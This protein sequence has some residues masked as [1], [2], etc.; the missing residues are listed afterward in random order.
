MTSFASLGSALQDAARRWKDRPA[1]ITPDCTWTYGEL[2]RQA[3]AYRAALGVSGMA[4]RE[5]VGVVCQNIMQ[6]AAA[7]VAT[8]LEGRVVLGVDSAIPAIR[9]RAIMEDAGVSRILSDPGTAA[10]CREVLPQAAVLLPSDPGEERAAAAG[11]TG[12]DAAALF[13]TS[14]STG[15]PKGVVL[16]HRAVLHEV[17][18]HG[19]TLG[20]VP[21]DRL[22]ALYSLSVLGSNRDFYAALLHG[23]AWCPFPFREH[24]PGALVEWLQ[25]SRSTIYHSVPAVFRAVCGAMGNA[26]PL[27]HLRVVFLAGDRVGWDDVVRCGRHCPNAR[28]YTGLGCS[29]TSSLYVHH[30]VEGEAGGCT[31]LP[32]GIPVP[33]CAVTIVG[34]DR[35]P[36]GPGEEGE[37]A[38]CGA[39]LALGYWKRPDLTAEY[40]TGEP[41]AV[42][43][44]FFTGD[45]GC[46]IDG[47]LHYR[48]RRDDRVKI[49]GVR[50][51]LGAVE[52]ALRNCEGVSDAVVIPMQQSGATRLAAAVVDASGTWNPGGLRAAVARAVASAGVPS[53]IRIV[54]SLPRLANGKVDRRALA[55]AMSAEGGGEIA[56]LTD[57]EA[58]LAA[59][60]RGCLPE[61]PEISAQTTFA[62][63]GGDSLQAMQMALRI[64]ELMNVSVRP[65]WLGENFTL[66]QWASLVADAKN[67]DGDGSPPYAPLAPAEYRALRLFAGAWEAVSGTTIRESQG[68][69]LH[70]GEE[71]PSKAPL[72][73]VYGGGPTH[74]F[75]QLVAG[76]RKMILIPSPLRV[77][78]AADDAVDRYCEF[79]A[80]N[81]SER[82]PAGGIEIGGFCNN[83]AVASRLAGALRRR[84]V[85]INRSILV[86]TIAFAFEP[87]WARGT[88]PAAGLVH[89][90]RRGQWRELHGKWKEKVAVVTQTG[91][92]WAPA[93]LPPPPQERVTLV[94]SEDFGRGRKLTAD[95]GWKNTG[96]HYS[97]HYAGCRHMDF[98]KPPHLHDLVQ[99]VLQ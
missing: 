50:V 89:F 55:V 94:W 16:P 65:E 35:R 75:A 51:E 46:W 68:L 66:G 71:D 45:R 1:V 10:R 56:L 63:A 62:G 18:V 52:G 73:W 42:E 31:D 24:G 22:T 53:E 4:P 29:E 43:H 93:M 92:P 58:E 44:T 70:A 11:V 85:R 84:G 17:S 38:V 79:F 26:E 48:G 33:G 40:F 57:A 60:W 59:I 7:T 67:A 91:T 83:G 77:M 76:K 74:A 95:R 88:K 61:A 90:A 78:E 69:V 30:F 6:T 49:G 20:L 5:V 99:I 87:W 27:R 14:G 36:V 64:E 96:A 21:D 37:I 72:L 19:E 98:L 81:L 8:L 2:F 23:A 97:W 32:C 82:L 34:A 13:Y 80:R 54:R 39:D 47:M 15:E 12:D 3:A 28:F 25:Q 9:Q 41:G 86:D